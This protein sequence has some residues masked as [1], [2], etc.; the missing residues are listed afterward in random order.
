LPALAAAMTTQG[1]GASLS[2]VVAGTIVNE[3]GYPAS[4]LAGGATSSSP[5]RHDR[6]SP[7]ALGC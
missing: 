6:A 3:Y 1:I 5:V 7:G 4:H 2:T